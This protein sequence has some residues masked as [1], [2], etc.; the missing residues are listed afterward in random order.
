MAR[1]FGNDKNST[2]YFGDSLQL[3][4]WVLDS[5]ATNVSYDTADFGFYP[6]FVRGY[7]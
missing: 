4:N 3:T 1:M 7:E 2:K 6:R 5:G